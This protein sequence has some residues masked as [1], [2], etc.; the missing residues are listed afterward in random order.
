MD[1][2]NANTAGETRRSDKCAAAQFCCHIKTTP[3]D[4][5]SIVLEYGDSM[6]Q[7]NGRKRIN[8]GINPYGRGGTKKCKSCRL[9]KKK[10]PLLCV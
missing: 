10:V 2:E 4:L 6:E 7:A 3:L 1:T 5:V 9:A 8:E